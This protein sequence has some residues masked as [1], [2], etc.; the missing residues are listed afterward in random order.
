[1][2]CPSCGANASRQ[3]VLVE[4]QKQCTICHCVWKEV[5]LGEATIVTPGQTFLNEFPD[6]NQVL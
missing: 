3:E 6:P 1:M 5:T 2:N 4:T